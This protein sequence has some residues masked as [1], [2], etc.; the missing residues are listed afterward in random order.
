MEAFQGVLSLLLVLSVGGLGVSLLSKLLRLPT[1]VG[2]AVLGALIGPYGF[3]L[4]SDSEQIPQIAEIGMMALL[5]SIGL[6]FNLDMFRS[7]QRHI[8]VFGGLQFFV[9][10]AVGMALLLPLGIGWYD[11]L[12]YASAFALSSTA[13]VTKLLLERGEFATRYGTRSIS[14]LLFQD[15]A[16]V[17]LLILIPDLAAYGEAGDGDVAVLYEIGIILAEIVL[18]FVVIVFFGPRLMPMWMRFIAKSGS[19]EIFSINLLAIIFGFSWATEHFGFSL[20]LG[21]FLAGM[22]LAETPQKYQVEEIISPFREIFLGFFFVA[23]GTLAD[24]RLVLEGI[25]YILAAV[26]GIL[27]VKT[28]TIYLIS[29][30]ESR[31]DHA[32]NLRVAV[33]LGGTGEF[34]FVLLVAAVSYLDPEWFSIF[35][36]SSLVA[37]AFTPMIWPALS[38]RLSRRRP[39]GGGEESRAPEPEKDEMKHV[40]IF[41]FGRTGRKIVE[42][43]R[44]EDITYAGIEASTELAAKAKE[45]REPVYRGGDTQLDPETVEACGLPRA[46]AV[47]ITFVEPDVVLATIAQVRNV[48]EDALIIAKTTHKDHVAE[49]KEAGA[50]EVVVEAAEG[51][52]LIAGLAM[53][54]FG[55]H[56]MRI[57]HLTA[58]VGGV[59][60]ALASSLGPRE[61]GWESNPSEAPR[62]QAVN[63]MEG[64]ASIGK[65]LTEA[66]PADREVEVVSLRRGG[67]TIPIGKMPQIRPND[68]LLLLGRPD[69]LYAVERLLM[70]GASRAPRSGPVKTSERKG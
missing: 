29:W 44:R 19:N 33:A 3:E 32:H 11:S 60:G 64:A 59:A 37:M 34:S 39:A 41:G 22:L 30:A 16:V 7:L 40:V 70:S 62:V 1:I 47:L 38:E 63:I 67:D 58:E 26:V 68:V 18:L 35:L 36:M 15:L 31:A 50:D 6:K 28:G 53:G 61:I 14:A 25:W 5:F 9:C 12:I 43:L 42:M 17:L 57:Q 54:M 10:T 66:V 69:D 20:A 2:Y 65:T 48:N 8:F 13:V 51:G 24:F 56:P 46:D 23:L 4:L 49:L 21:A 45:E 52:V 27:A 55:V